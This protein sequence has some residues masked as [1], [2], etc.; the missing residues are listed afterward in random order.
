MRCEEIFPVLPGPIV[1]KIET[2]HPGIRS[3]N[4]NPRKITNT[5]RDFSSKIPD[6]F[7]DCTGIPNII[8]NRQLPI[9][10]D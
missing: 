8:R 4:Q 10:N 3:F 1:L 6:Y 7:P 5:R 9:K 2:F